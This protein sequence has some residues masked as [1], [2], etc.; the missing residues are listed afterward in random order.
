MSN[1]HAAPEEIAV[2]CVLPHQTQLG[3]IALHVWENKFKTTEKTYFPNH[4][5]VFALTLQRYNKRTHMVIYFNKAV[6]L[7]TC[8]LLDRM[9]GYKIRK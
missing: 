4:V 2:S 5:I 3:A 6:L 1:M 7:E 9:S 8:L